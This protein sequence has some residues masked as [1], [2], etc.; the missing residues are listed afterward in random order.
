MQNQSMKNL[1]DYMRRS[2]K[3]DF[4]SALVDRHAL[5]Q[6]GKEWLTAALDPFHDYNHQIAGYPDTDVSQTVVSCFQYEMNLK[7]PASVTGAATW[8]AHVFTLP[9]ASSFANAPVYNETADWGRVKDPTPAVATQMG[10]LN[11]FSAPSG[12]VLGFTIPVNANSLQSVLPNPGV[13]DLASG[14]SRVISCG[15]EVH[16]TTAEIYK[17][18]AVTTYRMPQSANLNQVLF[19][20]NAETSFGTVTGKRLRAPPRTLAQVN[21]LKGTRTWEAKDGCYATVFQSTVANPLLQVSGEHV[22]FD[23]YPD[24]GQVAVVQGTPLIPGL[25]TANPTTYTPSACQ[26]MPFDTTGAIFTGLSAQTTLTVKARFYVELAPT[27]RE[28]QLAVLASPSAGYDLAA[29]QLYSQVINML[30]AAVMVHENAKGDWWRAVVSVLKHV[31]APLGLAMN[32]FVPGS[33]LVGS[34]VS[35]LAGQIDTKRSV[36]AQSVA[37]AKQVR[38]VKEVRVLNA[39]PKRVKKSAVRK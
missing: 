6:D 21:L 22:L 19:T 11:A 7:A 12:D 14:N 10:P 38:P 27:W 29:L 36:S 2:E 18:G 8:D 3:T 32:T 28:S 34:A 24:P 26:V 30:P 1:S 17:Q 25:P 31:S 5:T 23:E 35:A 9:I 13:E 39:K 37:Q 15:F 33:A 4:L 16:N 20:N